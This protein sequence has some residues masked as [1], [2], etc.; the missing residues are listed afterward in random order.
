MTEIPR[1]EYPIAVEVTIKD[2]GVQAD[3]PRAIP[4]EF[5]KKLRE[6]KLKRDSSA[7]G[8][9]IP[10]D[11]GLVAGTSPLSDHVAE[12]A[13]KQDTVTDQVDKIQGLLNRGGSQATQLLSNPKGAIGATMLPLA[14]GLGPVG[15]A[16]TTALATGAMA[17]KLM[18]EMSR[19]G[20]LLDESWRRVFNDGA[21]DFLSLQQQKDRLDGTAP[22]VI[23]RHSGYRPV[24]ATAV[25]NSLLR[26]DEV[27]LRRAGQN[28]YGLGLQ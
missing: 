12:I 9:A 10:A 18:E 2:E 28:A 6:S 19:R 26:A 11:S 21:N 13:E 8:T 1:P 20:G 7:G 16:F 23:A 14:A 3:D 4:K 24:P 22:L 27:R 5:R 17:F 15:I 25:Y